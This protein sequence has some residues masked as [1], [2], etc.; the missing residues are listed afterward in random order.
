MSDAARKRA[1]AM[2]KADSPSFIDAST[3]YP[4]VLHEVL[5]LREQVDNTR[6]GLAA[7]PPDHPL[8]AKIRAALGENAD[9]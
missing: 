1:E 4:A 7:L 5:R 6:E 2:A 3:G 8:A 9:G